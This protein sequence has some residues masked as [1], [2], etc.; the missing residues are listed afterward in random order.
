MLD[1]VID[2]SIYLLSIYQFILNFYFFVGEE[3]CFLRLLSASSNFNAEANTLN[4]FEIDNLKDQSP[5]ISK[6]V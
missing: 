2:I 5:F 4:I 1:F 6:M 3:I